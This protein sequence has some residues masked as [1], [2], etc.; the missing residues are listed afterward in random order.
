MGR[1]QHAGGGFP[2]FGCTDD[3]Y[4]LTFEENLCDQYKFCASRSVL[5]G[6][7]NS[8]ILLELK[9]DEGDSVV[10]YIKEKA[11]NYMYIKC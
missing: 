10:D 7:V 6:G 4:V 3:S 8:N 9:T 11:Y 5:L 2:S 1:T